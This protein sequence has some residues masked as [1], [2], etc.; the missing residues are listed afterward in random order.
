[1][2]HLIHHQFSL[3]TVSPEAH[4]DKRKLHAVL[5]NQIPIDDTLMTGHIDSLVGGH[6]AVCQILEFSIVQDIQIDRIKA[7]HLQFPVHRHEM[8]LSAGCHHDIIG[9]QLPQQFYHSD[10]VQQTAL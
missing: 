5:S 7:V 3:G 4:P 6:L 10:S 9:V 8:I 1:M 2:E